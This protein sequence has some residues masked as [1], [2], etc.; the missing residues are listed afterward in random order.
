MSQGR[1]GA[2]HKAKPFVDTGLLLKLLGKHEEL[3]KDFKSYDGLSRNSAV[4]PRGLVNVL[5]FVNDVLE[6]SPSCEVHPQPL[7]NSLLQLL[8]N[9]PHL[10]L[11][12]FNGSVWVNMKAERVGVVLHHV[13]RL[14]R[15]GPNSSCTSSLTGMEY[16]WLKDTLAKVE[17]RDENESQPTKAEEE[18]DTKVDPLESKPCKRLRAKAS[19][20]SVDDAGFPKMLDSPPNK[21][22]ETGPPRIFNKKK[23]KVQP[24]PETMLDLRESMG[25]VMKKPCTKTGGSLKKPCTK[26]GGPLKKGDEVSERRPWQVLRKTT[27][28]KPERCYLTGTQEKG[29]KLKLI[30]EVKKSWSNRYPLVID[31][32]KESLEKDH[33]TKEEALALREQLCK[34]YP[35]SQTLHTFEKG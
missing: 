11:T 12:K 22:S 1:G 32:I 17:L 16:Q 30:V 14:A 18:E 34:K 9:K 2:R 13:R 24:E 25:W 5:H 3:I 35:C 26:T 7:R 4:D 21:T 29:G 31:K 10:N 6:L 23:I 15:T 27:A 20:V 33:L 28:T 8:S 19:D